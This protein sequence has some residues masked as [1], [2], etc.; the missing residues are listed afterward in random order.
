[1]Q[2]Y[3]ISGWK[4]GVQLGYNYNGIVD[5]KASF[6]Y[7]PQDQKKGYR[8]GFDRAEMI[9]DVQVKV[10]PIKPLAITLGYEL[11]AN[12]CYYNYYGSIGTPPIESWGREELDNV[13]R[14]SLDAS[15]Q[16]NKTVG[17]FVNANNL[18][19]QKWDEFV[20]MGVQQINALAGVNIMF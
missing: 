16:I 9:A 2:K 6:Q 20:G 8:T 12:R 11:R 19:N 17:V 14:L 7:S 3:E 13:N 4:A 1:M 18:L 15:Y 5:A 10:T